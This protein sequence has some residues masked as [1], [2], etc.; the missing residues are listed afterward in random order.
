M[1][2]KA[3]Q[4]QHRTTRL[5][6]AVIAALVTPLC[7]AGQ[8]R[9]ESDLPAQDWIERTR[10]IR[11]AVAGAAD[12]DPQRIAVFIDVLDVSA[13]LVRTA[14]GWLYD[15]AVLPLPS[16][17]HELVA[18]VVE[19]D[20][21]FT[22]ALRQPFGVPRPLGIEDVAF[23]PTADIG[24]KSR[25]AS[26]FEPASPAERATYND[27]DG[28]FGIDTEIERYD[29]LRFS[30]RSQIVGVSER[31]RALRY[32]ELADSAPRI[33]LSSYVAQV[34]RGGIELAVGNISA[35]DARHLISRF[36]SRGA[37]VGLAMGSRVDVAAAALHGSNLVG[38]DQLI[39][40]GQPDHRIISGSVG[41]EALDQPGALRIELTALDG[42]V[43]PR[44][45]FNRGAITDAETSTGYAVRVQSQ[46]FDRRLRLEGG[47]THSAFDNP[48]DDLLGRDTAIVDVER[49]SRNARYIQASVDVLHDVRL[50][51][52]RNARLTVGYEHERVDP[53]FRTV[54]SHTRADQLRNRWEARGDV[55]GVTVSLNHARSRN[56]LDD[57]ES[58]LTSNT[59]RTGYDVSVPLTTVLRGSAWLP[60]LR[61]GSDRTHQFGT[62]VPV[63]G[64]FSETHVPDQV[65]TD[66]TASIDMRFGPASVGYRLNLSEQDN[67]QTGRENADLERTTHTVNV[68]A[69]PLRTLSLRGEL[70]RIEA[71]SVEREETDATRRVAFGIDW[72]LLRDAVLALALSDTDSDND[73]DLSGRNDR[74]WSLQWSSPVPGLQRFGGKWLLRFA[75]AENSATDPSGNAV[76]R[77]NWMIDTGFNFSFR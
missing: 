50:G 30:T 18:Y 77:N 73:V 72:M 35:G 25:V 43:L 11:F 29:G 26:A 10:Q 51:A 63:N 7:A 20:G 32:G 48:D 44:S 22:E 53:L 45:G 56:N 75:R 52:S 64:G 41:L 62:G 2:P 9:I 67:R 49:E 47:F 39:G 16:G 71:F 40:I 19:D 46:A 65:S 74:T 27:L 6:A 24:L 66:R 31:H 69:S 54:A 13:L 21:R 55:G 17:Q 28:R 34:K 42:S 3:S 36:S 58:I 1:R 23:K 38:L 59:H 76:E 5:V 15:P 60:Q 68:T 12:A 14:D 8:V 57:I 37:S 33:D 70:S 61:F 4:R